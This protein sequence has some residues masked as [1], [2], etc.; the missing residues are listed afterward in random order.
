MTIH[1]FSPFT[2]KGDQG[3]RSN[4]QKALKKEPDT[5]DNEDSTSSVVHSQDGR[6]G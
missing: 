4:N 1:H 6:N 2:E 3:A 5:E